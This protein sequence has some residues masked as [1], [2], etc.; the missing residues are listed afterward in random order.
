MPVGATFLT[1]LNVLFIA[2][3]VLEARRLDS[4]FFLEG[5]SHLTSGIT[6]PKDISAPRRLMAVVAMR[7]PRSGLLRAPPGTADPL[8]ASGQARSPA[9]GPTAP[10]GPPERG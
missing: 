3:P 10:H 2:A 7:R 6:Y 9:D 1:G 4:G 5:N 8:P